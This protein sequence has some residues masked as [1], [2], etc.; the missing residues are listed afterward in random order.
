MK[1]KDIKTIIAEAASDYKLGLQAP[2]YAQLN[3]GIERLENRLLQ[4]V[5][6]WESEG[7]DAGLSTQD[8]ISHCAVSV[9]QAERLA[10]AAGKNTLN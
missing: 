8:F 3:G 1:K 9:S 10:M 4:L 7:D 5:S 2:D 6:I